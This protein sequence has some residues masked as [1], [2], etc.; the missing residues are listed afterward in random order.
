MVTIPL[1]HRT[2]LPAVLVCCRRR[3]GVRSRWNSS[4][5][6]SHTAPGVHPSWRGRARA[7]CRFARLRIDGEIPADLSLIAV[8]F[9]PARYGCS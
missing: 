6:I 1:F 9:R 4:G 3:V 7:A 2:D 8:H 5:R